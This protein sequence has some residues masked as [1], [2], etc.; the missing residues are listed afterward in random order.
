M[1]FSCHHCLKLRI[2][3]ADI[4]FPVVWGFWGKK[5]WKKLLTGSPNLP[6]EIWHEAE[7]KRGQ[8]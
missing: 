8:N 6:L 4:K 1:Q 7:G 5:S 2:S 3:N